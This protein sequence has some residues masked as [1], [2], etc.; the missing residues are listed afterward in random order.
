MP[1]KHQ[2][3]PSPQPPL[4]MKRSRLTPIPLHLLAGAASQA[5]ATHKSKLR[6]AQG[7]PRHS[8][9]AEKCVSSGGEGLREDFGWKLNKPTLALRNHA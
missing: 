7:G 4:A 6:D 2:V 1:T 5:T 8:V 3:Q 9:C